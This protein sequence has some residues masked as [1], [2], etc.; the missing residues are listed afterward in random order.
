MRIFILSLFFLTL[1]STEKYKGFV[2]SLPSFFFLRSLSILGPINGSL[3]SYFQ[4]STHTH[5][6][7]KKSFF[8]L[9]ISSMKFNTLLT[10][11]CYR[12]LA[13]KSNPAVELI[14]RNILAA[15]KKKSVELVMQSDTECEKP[16]QGT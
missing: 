13:L 1:D 4:L 5:E 8:D 7:E 6:K 16:H 3:L 9:F 12:T 14:I 15:I 10:A 11:F 2:F